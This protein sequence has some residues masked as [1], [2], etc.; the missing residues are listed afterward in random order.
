MM[1]GGISVE[2]EATAEI[3]SVCNELIDCALEK[4]GKE[5]FDMF[6]ALKYTTQVVAGTNFFVKVQVHPNGEC[7]H[8]RIFKPLP[9]TNRPVELTSVQ[10]GKAIEDT[11]DYF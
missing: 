11:I 9:H 3:Q 8:V 2:K 5:E 1:C 6:T 7:I 10:T 4:S